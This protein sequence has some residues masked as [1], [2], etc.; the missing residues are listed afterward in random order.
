MS[1][2]WIHHFIRNI[3][4]I[5]NYLKRKYVVSSLVYYNGLAY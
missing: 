3:N 4:I 2:Q 5:S 1:L